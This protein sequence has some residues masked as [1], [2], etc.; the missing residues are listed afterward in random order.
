[1]TEW[2]QNE[3]VLLDWNP[4]EIPIDA[5]PYAA[6]RADQWRRFGVKVA[7][8]TVQIGGRTVYESRVAKKSDLISGDVIGELV[9]A[10]KQAEVRL[11]AG[12]NGTIHA[13][14]VEVKRHPDWQMRRIDGSVEPLTCF[15][16]PYREFLFEQI[17]EIV[18]GYDVDGVYFDQVSV[19]CFCAYCK[20]HYLELYGEPMPLDSIK[21]HPTHHG[22]T[23]YPHP[24]EAA[25]YGLSRELCARLQNLAREQRVSWAWNVRKIL[26]AARPGLALVL[27]QVMGIAAGQVRDYATAYLPEVNLGR[28]AD[29][30]EISAERALTSL[31][32]Q[33][34]LWE[35][36]KYSMN[37]Q[38]VHAP[39]Q[40]FIHAAEV[41][42]NDSNMI[43]TE[44]GTL[45]DRT[46]SYRREFER[47]FRRFVEI[48]RQ[49]YGLKPMA[50][51]GIL[52][53]ESSWGWSIPTTDESFHGAV[54]LCIENHIPHRIL[55][56]EEIV[57][58]E[59]DLAVIVVPEAISLPPQ[60]VDALIAYCRKGGGLIVTGRSGEL[61]EDGKPASN[62][63]LD[64]LMGVKRAAWRSVK[65][66][67][68]PL[69]PNVPIDS[70]HGTDFMYARIRDSKH[71]VVADLG[72]ALT[73][74]NAG[75][76][77]FESQ[78]AEV[79]ADVVGFDQTVINAEFFSRAM[80]RPG[81]AVAPLAAVNERERCRTAYFAF[82]ICSFP[83]RDDG[84]ELE[85]LFM[86]ALLWCGGKPPLE[87]TDLPRTTK[88]TVWGGKEDR[89]LFV[90]MRGQAIESSVGGH[91]VGSA[92]IFRA[93]A[94]TPPGVVR[95]DVG[96]AVPDSWN[97]FTGATSAVEVGGDGALAIKYGAFELIEA[98]EVH[99]ENPS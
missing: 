50:H 78:G 67:P 26:D 62:R 71:P 12:W 43:V 65:R 52:H 86:N 57:R 36:V 90:A 61:S 18:T 34:P 25:E 93:S 85:R 59:F 20:Q 99:L 38:R 68:E 88:I 73:H 46:E 40:T 76:V 47:E 5:K 29:L 72:D 42:T 75:H 19:G 84:V 23:V 31:Y 16:S 1:M 28:R 30:L 55:S 66:F 91:G 97:S 77:E 45:G 54:R 15:N 70:E 3:T 89:R 22:G 32:G 60:V 24:G 8:H 96:A 69:W 6:S 53:S 4:I 87:T 63:A 58:G 94:P 14:R 11:I 9:R 10:A 56:E 21:T 95:L 49:S 39:R 51:V 74:F 37:N 17:N 98:L 41:I 48:R 13:T 92:R 33:G 81:L 27:N 82:P 2:L 7:V 35:V 80:A 79:V 64:E 83:V 44:H